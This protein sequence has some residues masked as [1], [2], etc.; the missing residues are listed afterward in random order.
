MRSF[1]DKIAA[2]ARAMEDCDHEWIG[3]VKIMVGHYGDPD[4]FY[5]ECKHCPLVKG[6]NTRAEAKALVEAG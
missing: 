5:V 6:T 3:P 4:S 2:D 1:I